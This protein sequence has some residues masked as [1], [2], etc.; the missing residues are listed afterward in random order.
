MDYP[1][2]PG[3]DV[4]WAFGKTNNFSPSTKEEKATFKILF[5]PN[6]DERLR[7]KRESF[8]VYLAVWKEGFD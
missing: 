3:N 2:E 5:R 4:S 8:S 7:H 6:S 1:V